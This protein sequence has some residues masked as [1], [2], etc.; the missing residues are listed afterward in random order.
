MLPEWP[1]EAG[2]DTSGELVE[3]GCWHWGD[4]LSWASSDVTL[5][6]GL[7][8]REQLGMALSSLRTYQF[9]DYLAGLICKM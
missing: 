5:N 4:H 3:P 6:H 2:M 7:L 8:G 9:V 1:S